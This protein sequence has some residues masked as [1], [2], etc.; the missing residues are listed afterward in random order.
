MKKKIY[1]QP[2]VEMA[3]WQ[4]GMTMIS[5]SGDIHTNGTEP[6]EGSQS[7]NRAPKLF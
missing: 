7:Q 5:A 4:G 6:V 3:S 1:I 2:M